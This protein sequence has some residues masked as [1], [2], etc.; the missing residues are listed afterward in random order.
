MDRAQ[1]ARACTETL[2]IIK[3]FPQEDYSKIPSNIIEY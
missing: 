3:Y 1:Y 2:E